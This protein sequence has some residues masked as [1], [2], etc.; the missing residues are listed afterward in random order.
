MVKLIGVAWTLATFLVV[1]VL[2]TRDVGPID[3]VKESAG[4]LRETWGENLIGNVGLGLVFAVAYL[5]C[6]CG[7]G[8]PSPR[9]RAAG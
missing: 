1:P 2:V 3:A 9:D 5:A 7:A 6:C 4:L 8:P